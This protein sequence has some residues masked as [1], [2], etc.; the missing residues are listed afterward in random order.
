MAVVVVAVEF[1]HGDGEGFFGLVHQNVDDGAI[2]SRGE[3]GASAS[4]FEEFVQ[5]YFRRRIR[6]V[7]IGSL[8]PPSKHPIDLTVGEEFLHALF[9]RGHG[10]DVRSVR[11]G[12]FGAEFLGDFGKVEE[13]LAMGGGFDVVSVSTQ[14][15]SVGEI[16]DD[17]SRDSGGGHDSRQSGGLAN[18]PL[19]DDHDPRRPFVR[20]L[21]GLDDLLGNI[22]DCLPHH[23]PLG[24][25]IGRQF[26][27]FHHPS[28]SFV[29]M[30]V[31]RIDEIGHPGLVGTREEF[32]KGI[33]PLLG[34][35]G[36]VHEDGNDGFSA[37]VHDVD[38]S[39]HVG[40]FFVRFDLGVRCFPDLALTFFSDTF[41]ASLHHLQDVLQPPLDQLPKLGQL[42]QNRFP[43]SYLLLDALEQ[44]VHL[45]LLL[46]PLR[47]LENPEQIVVNGELNG[48]AETRSYVEFAV[49]GV[50]GG[51][52]VSRVRRGL[53]GEGEG[54]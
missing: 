7:A 41:H 42:G 43:L 53:W 3:G 49:F 26:P 18:T 54:G 32:G 33:R 34:R 30:H 6:C 14:S 17:V 47:H 5:G 50:D 39:F 44:F 36:E 8:V 24:L 28:D 13:S 9:R 10:T 25:L 27:L 1:V 52:A 35:G 38:E 23:N 40:W 15:V 12:E 46:A 51:G 29:V 11:R 45:L 22:L 4:D 19:S 37:D 2:T 16:G 48:R 21:R 31:Q 20:T